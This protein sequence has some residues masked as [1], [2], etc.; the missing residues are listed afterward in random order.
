M[1]STY[2]HLY[3]C[4]SIYE[5]PVGSIYKRYV[6]SP[7]LKHFIQ[8][9]IKRT[10][11]CIIT[12]ETMQRCSNY[13]FKCGINLT[14]SFF[15]HNFV[16]YILHMFLIVFEMRFSLVVRVINFFPNNREGIILFNWIQYGILKVMQSH[17]I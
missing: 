13:K 16:Y 12:Q 7:I 2:I 15:T 14:V 17:G 6:G 5:S 8:S 3:F 1:T 4:I 9:N 11:A 10:T